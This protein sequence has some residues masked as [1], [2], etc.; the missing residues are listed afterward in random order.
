M[1]PGSQLVA[2]DDADWRVT[3]TDTA[4][5]TSWLHGQIVIDDKPL[6]EVV[7]ELN[8]YSDRKV[9][10]ADATL[11]AAH[12]SGIFRPGD[13]EGLARAIETSRLGKVSESNASELRIVAMK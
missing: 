1:G 8:R 4:R 5:E 6:S 12:L 9:V 13:L 11:G 7:E 10:L 3:R 2:P